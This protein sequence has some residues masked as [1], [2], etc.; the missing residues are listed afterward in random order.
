MSRE[1]EGFPQAIEAEAAAVQKFVD[2]LQLEQKALSAGN[3]EELPGLAEQKSKLAIDL[4]RLAADRNIS[5]A[6]QG[7]G[8]DRVGVAAWCV[9][10]PKNH[11]VGDAWTRILACAHEARELNRVNGELIRIRMQYNANALAALQGGTDALDLYGPDGQ[12]TTPGVRRIND[13]A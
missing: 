10:H 4:S 9:K 11:R 6:A 3:T 8:A 7:F 12:S 13:A 1:A 2:L 5:L